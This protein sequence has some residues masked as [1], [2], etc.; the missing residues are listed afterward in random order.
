MVMVSFEGEERSRRTVS[1]SAS[2]LRDRGRLKARSAALQQVLLL[3][4]QQRIQQVVAGS[5]GPPSP[6]LE[7]SSSSPSSLGSTGSG[8][9]GVG[10]TEGRGRRTHRRVGSSGEEV[11]NMAAQGDGDEM[12]EPQHSGWRRSGEWLMVSPHHS[13]SMQHVFRPSS[14]HPLPMQSRQ[15]AGPILGG[16]SVLRTKPASVLLQQPMLQ[17]YMQAGKRAPLSRSETH[18]PSLGTSSWSFSANT[19]PSATGSSSAHAWSVV[20]PI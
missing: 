5:S 9:P 10:R 7:S 18:A 19:S 1:Q 6:L 2:P 12:E 4:Q 16:G 3:Q 20:I 13:S 15:V 8:S 11:G 17:K 14:A